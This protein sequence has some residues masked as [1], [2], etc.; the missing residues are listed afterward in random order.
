M[1]KPQAG[2]VKLPPVFYLLGVGE[3]YLLINI[4]YLVY[5]VEIKPMIL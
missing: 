5:A 2:A 4:N 1:I 3:C